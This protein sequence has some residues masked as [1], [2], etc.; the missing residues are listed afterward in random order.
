MKPMHS[1]AMRV[2]ARGRCSCCATVFGRHGSGRSK[3]QAKLAARLGK[4]KARAIG[5]KIAQNHED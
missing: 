4:R 5:K 3:N 1:E 2:G